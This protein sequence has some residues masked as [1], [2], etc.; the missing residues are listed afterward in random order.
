M[1]L[2]IFHVNKRRIF[3]NRLRYAMF[4]VTVVLALVLSAMTTAPVLADET[5]PPSTDETSGGSGSTEEAAP[6]EAVVA[7]LLQSAPEGTEVIITSESGEVLPLASS[8]AAEV[9]TLSDPQWCPAGV[10]P[11]SASCSGV[12]TSFNGGNPSN[13]LIQWLTNNPQSKAG[14]IWIESTYVGTSGLEGGAITLNGSTLSSMSAFTLTVNGGWVSGTTLNPN[15]PS[16]FEVPFAIVNWNNAVTINNIL[17]RNATGGSGVQALEVSAD[18]NITLNNVDLQNNAT[19]GAYLNNS[20]AS[21][22]KNIVVNDSTFDGNSAGDGL[23]IQTNGTVTAK[24]LSANN[25]SGSGVYIDNTFTFTPKAV[26]FTGSNNFSF[27]GSDGLFIYSRGAITLSNVTA[28]YNTNGSGVVA[29]NCLWDNSDPDHFWAWYCTTGASPASVTIKGAVNNFS[30]NGWDGLRVLSSGTITLANI[31]AN[32]NGT[33][34]ARPGATALTDDDAPDAYG[35]GAFLYNYG[36]WTQK[37]ITLTGTNTFNGNASTGLYVEAY[38]KV[39]VNNLTASDNSCDILKEESY[40]CDGAYLDG[41]GVTQTGYGIFNDNYDEGLYVSSFGAVS[42]SSLSAEGNGWSGVAVDSYGSASAVTL[43]GTHTFLNNGA[44][45]L[46]IFTE[47]AVTLGNITANDNLGGG[48]YIGNDTKCVWDD[49]LN[50]CNFVPVGKPVTLSGINTFNGNAD[51]GLAIYSSGVITTNNITAN[52]NGYGVNLNNCVYVVIDDNGTPGNTSDD[53]WDCIGGLVGKTVT[54]NGANN[55]NGNDGNGL[56]VESLGVIK[57]NNLT[58]TGN[59]AVGATLDNNW[60]GATAGVT[61]TGFSDTSFNGEGG[62]RIY[63]HGAVLTSNLTANF[64]GPISAASGDQYYRGVYINNGTD[65]TKL[66]SVTLM[67]VNTFN[68]N[69]NTGLGIYS[70]GAITLNNITANGNG[71]PFEVSDNPTPEGYGIEV[72]NSNSSMAKAVTLNGINTFNDNFN[73]GLSVSSKGAILV[74]K[75]TANDNGGSGANLNN[76]FG[77]MSTPVTILGYGI[78]NGN[79]DTG[80]QLYSNGVVITNSLTANLN[81]GNGVYID[82]EFNAMPTSAV[83][84]TMNGVNT[85]NGNSSGT[86]LV[87]YSDGIITLNN[88]TANDNSAY[89][90]YLDN[91][92]NGGI[93]KNIILNGN[94][95]FVNNTLSG[96][97]FD[98]SGA[99][100]MT[101]V[102]A[103]SNGDDGIQGA[104]AGTITLTCASLILND[105]SGYELLSSGLITLKGV[106]TFGN[107]LTPVYTGTPLI[108]R[109]CPLP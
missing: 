47:G 108:T 36:A 55:I 52:G 24:N 34:A 2:G 83:N 95:S 76:Q 64:N 28:I 4:V 78:F 1:V 41:Y 99:V 48:V 60:T 75:V 3:M 6:E 5:T 23:A 104:A 96:L 25:N 37:A 82:N 12:K 27:N 79:D 16:T 58:A 107:I 31:T 35:K 42:L 65:P 98:A 89:G 17:I 44:D 73:D 106:F 13:N 50:E 56:Y 90:A 81:T 57:V 101:R 54:M 32:D 74:N 38:G 11:G 51:Y 77:V 22:S 63:T 80:L 53:I 72:N 7:E 109:T 33:D 86:G 105:E 66:M 62:L 8:E 88:I 29:D 61:I 69:W 87:V 15:T 91:V 9:A 39:S 71:E 84:V 14:V 40:F 21:I 103:A 85:F 94:N 30:N 45:G 46:F 26:T 100:T 19:N 68:G 43:L 92:L 93:L 102:T 20:F 18:G 67:G 97:A 49:N 10:A 70:F 59:G